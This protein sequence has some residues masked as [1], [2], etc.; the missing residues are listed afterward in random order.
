[1]DIAKH[2]TEFMDTHLPIA[3]DLGIQL[4]HYQGD[5]LVLSAPLEPNINDKATAFGGSI[6]CVCVMSCWG[7]V[8]L[9]AKEH[10]ITSPNIVVSHAEIDYMRPVA[11]EIVAKCQLESA[12]S[13]E[14][15]FEAHKEKG[16]AKIKL[17]SVVEHNNKTAVKFFGHYALIQ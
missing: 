3:A 7:M 14:P 12:D 11:G 16:K 10:G 4:A 5:Q 9:K 6:Y 8:Y 2:L 13:F 17:N 15:F 1:M